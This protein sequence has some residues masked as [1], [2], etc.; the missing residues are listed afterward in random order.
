VAIHGD[1]TTERTRVIVEDN[2]PG[3]D[4]TI[5]EYIFD[6]FFSGRS[7]GRGRGLGLSTAWRLAKQ[8]GGDIRYERSK[9]GLTRFILSLPRA[10]ATA[11]RLSA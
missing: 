10:D 5:L 6:P 8:Q 7:A 11:D 4:P 9:D 3:V 2:G 1:A